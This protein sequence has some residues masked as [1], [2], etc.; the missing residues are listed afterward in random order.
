MLLWGEIIWN[1]RF[2]NGF[3]IAFPRP[4]MNRAATAGKAKVEE[5]KADS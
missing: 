3:R 5:L 1:E 4:K 2:G